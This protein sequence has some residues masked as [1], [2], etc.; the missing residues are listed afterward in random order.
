M[1]GQIT[2]ARECEPAPGPATRWPE[3][4]DGPW[5]IDPDPAATN[6]AARQVWHFAQ[7]RVAAVEVA[8]V[9]LSPGD[10]RL[11]FLGIRRGAEAGSTR[12]ASPTTP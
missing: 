5:P 9:T 12:P 8:G 1:R 2:E 11:P 3:T 4:L 7:A 6:L 10:P